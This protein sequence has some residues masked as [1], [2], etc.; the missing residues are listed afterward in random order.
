MDYDT[1][2]STVS[3]LRGSLQM[4][5]DDIVDCMVAL[6]PQLFYN[7]QIP[8]CLWF[9]NMRKAEHR[10]GQT[11][12]IDARRMGYLVDRTLRDLSDDDIAKITGTYH[13][14]RTDDDNYQDEAGFCKSATLGGIA[15]HG[16]VLT[17]GRYV[18]A[19]DMDE[20]DE[21]FVEKMVRLTTTLQEQF[22]E[23]ARLEQII[24]DNLKRLGYEL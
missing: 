3:N 18:G 17:P 13:A 20:D 12:F 1:A 19:P 22:A 16:Y 24:R 15:V 5:E 23:S 8:S 14:W 2:F 6:P 10:H 11:L 9:L 21:P 7:T 4:I